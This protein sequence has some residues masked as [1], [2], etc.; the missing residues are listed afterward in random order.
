M[1]VT[2]LFTTLIPLL[3]RD[4]IEMRQVGTVYVLECHIAE[5]TSEKEVL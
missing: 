2:T 4:F 1:I 3:S 5:G